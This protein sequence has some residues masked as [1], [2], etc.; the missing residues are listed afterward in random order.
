MLMSVYVCCIE[1]DGSIYG[2]VKIQFCVAV[3]LLFVLLQPMMLKRMEAVVYH[4]IHTLWLMRSARHRLDGRR[5]QYSV[6]VL[7][8]LQTLAMCY[9]QRH[10][11]FHLTV[12]ASQA[13]IAG[14]QS[15]WLMTTFVRGQRLTLTVNTLL[16]PV[17]CVIIL[18]EFCT[19][20]RSNVLC[21]KE[22][23]NNCFW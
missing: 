8:I 9:H 17:Y 14:F 19:V 13:F 7:P 11:C 16:L 12:P 23:I 20:S 15:V 22:H 2:T 6:A 21:T 18:S 1:L 10:L 5:W 4:L 3:I